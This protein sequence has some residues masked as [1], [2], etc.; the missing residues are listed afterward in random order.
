MKKK[1]QKNPRSY[2]YSKKG[3]LCVIKDSKIYSIETGNPIR[4]DVPKDTVFY[5]EREVGVN[6]ILIHTGKW[7]EI[8]KELTEAQK[9]R[10]IK[11]EQILEQNTM[12]VSEEADI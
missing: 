10:N 9:K 8:Y 12:L 11:R 1:I 3:R 4:M 6:R 5:T 7:D 2:F